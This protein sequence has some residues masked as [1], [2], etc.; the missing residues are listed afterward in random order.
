MIKGAHWNQMKILWNMPDISKF[1]TDSKNFGSSSK[2]L[3][4]GLEADAKE[5]SKINEI[6]QLATGV[7]EKVSG[8]QVSSV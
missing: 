7:T 8:H 3:V 6:S 4:L 2:N 1:T 5:T